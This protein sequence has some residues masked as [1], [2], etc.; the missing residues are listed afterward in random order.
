MTRVLI[1]GGAGVFGGRLARILAK[2]ARFDLIIA[3]RDLA[4]A[5]AFAASLDGP[6]RVSALRI[7]AAAIGSALKECEPD[8]IVHCAGPFQGQ[9]YAVAKAAIAARIPYA[10]LSDG[11]AFSQGFAALDA[12]AKQAGVFALT[13]CSTTSALSAAAAIHLARDMRQVH[14]VRVGVTPGNRAP[15][16][17]A[18]VEAII[19]YVG[20]PIPAWRE[21]RETYVRGWGTLTREDL[22]GL[23][24]RWFSPCDAPDIIAMRELFP[25]ANDIEFL[26]GLELSIMHLPLWALAKLRAT[27]LTPNLAPAAAL[28]H[29]AAKLFEPF[30]SDQGGMFVEIA[31]TGA[32]GGDLARRWTIW[33]GSGDGP[34]IPAIAAAAIARRV[35]DGAPPAPG[36]RIAAGDVTLEEFEPEFVAFNIRTQIEDYDNGNHVSEIARRPV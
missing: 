34:Y 6:P 26:A 21:G 17:R 11:R 18:V 36:A 19:S 20:E 5:Q 25:A 13:A 32:D 4:R 22:P 23:G 24:G 9:D 7:D 1:L 15:R 3:G 33:A 2:D 10:D 16:G 12:P 27:G 28:F 8:L 14:R 35:A 31:G 30:G 29:Q